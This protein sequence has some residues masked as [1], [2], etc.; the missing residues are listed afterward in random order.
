MEITKHANRQRSG[1]SGKKEGP[2]IAVFIPSF[3]GGGAERMLLAVAQELADRGYRVDLI[4]ATAKGPYLSEVR[5]PLK[6]IDFKARGVLA[7]L[8]S[9]VKYLKREAP[10]VLFTGLGRCNLTAIWAQRFAE[11][12][13]RICISERNTLSMAKS[14]TKSLRGRVIPLFAKHWYPKADKILAVSN[15]V[16]KDLCATLRIASDRINVIYNPVVSKNIVDKSYETVT[17][18]W[19]TKQGPPIILGVGRLA[20]QKDFPTLIRAFALI[21]AKQPARLMILGEGT[22]RPRLEKMVYEMGL[23]NDVALPGFVDNRFAYMR[24]ADVFV[25]SSRW[26]GFGNAIAEAMACGCPAVCSDI[27][28]FKE[29]VQDGY[30]G[31]MVFVRSPEA[32]ADAI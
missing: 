29:I 15:G 24:Q 32:I 27:P 7:A 20:T 31:L 17:H 4:S 22:E 23:E 6:L 21:R 25:L 5:T 12:P 30:N 11:A 1:R 13:T 28:T 18:P 3:A 8:P 2:D 16:A 9:L 10:A 26:E 19:L 14:N